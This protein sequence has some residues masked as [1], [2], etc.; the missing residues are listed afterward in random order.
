[1]LQLTDRAV[2]IHADAE[3]SVCAVPNPCLT[4]PALLQ[5][6]SRS[7]CQ[8]ER[9]HQLKLICICQHITL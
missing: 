4:A 8:V 6:S 1:M 3:P 9:W 2:R 5:I 7:P